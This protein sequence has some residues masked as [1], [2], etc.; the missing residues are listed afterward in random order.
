MGVRSG[1]GEVGFCMSIF[2]LTVFRE[3]KIIIKLLMLWQIFHMQVH[4]WILVD[5]NWHWFL[6]LEYSRWVDTLV[7]S[8]KIYKPL[9]SY[10]CSR[11]KRSE[12]WFQDSNIEER[13]QSLPKLSELRNILSDVPWCQYQLSFPLFHPEFSSLIFLEFAILTGFFLSHYCCPLQSPWRTNSWFIKHCV[14]RKAS[15]SVHKIVRTVGCVLLFFT[16]N[17]DSECLFY[18]FTFFKCSMFF[19]SSLWGIVN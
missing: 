12:K 10:S 14:W 3:N 16:N 17:Q 2:N 9:A 4:A 8:L 13:F 18:S 5:L 19:W 15:I 11:D 7:Q 1:V 6:S